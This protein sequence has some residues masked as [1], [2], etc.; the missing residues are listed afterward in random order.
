MEKTPMSQINKGLFKDDF[1]NLVDPENLSYR[2]FLNYKSKT[3]LLTLARLAGLH[4]KQANLAKEDLAIFLSVEIPKVLP[5]LV[6]KLNAKD[7][8][9]CEIVISACGYMPIW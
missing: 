3:D 8:I 7:S 9:A 4:N 2:Y 6:D 5:T 1:G